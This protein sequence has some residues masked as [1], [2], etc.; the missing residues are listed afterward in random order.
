MTTNVESSGLSGTSSS[1]WLTPAIS[2]AF[3]SAVTAERPGR[4]LGG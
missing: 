1:S 3:S 4:S 2:W